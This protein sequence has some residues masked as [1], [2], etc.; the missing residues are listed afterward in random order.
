MAESFRIP[1][2]I[3]TEGG[4]SL[5]QRFSW[6]NGI[7]V[8]TLELFLFRRLPSGAPDHRTAG[9]GKYRGNKGPN[10]RRFHRLHGEGHPDQNQTPD[11]WWQL[12]RLHNRPH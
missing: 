5:L 8:V 4:K 3:I 2:N 7:L 12:N 6:I 10:F 1:Q 11:H 9:F